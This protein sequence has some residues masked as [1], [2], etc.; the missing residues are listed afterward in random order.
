[1]S[2]LLANSLAI[3]LAYDPIDYG[4]YSA[5]YEMGFMDAAIAIVE[6]DMLADQPGVG[7]PTLRG[8]GVAFD[9]NRIITS[10]NSMRPFVLTEGS[11]EKAY[12]VV[13]KGRSFSTHNRTYHHD[14]AVYKI[15]CGRQ[16]IYVD[17]IP[18]HLWFDKINQTSPYHDL[19]VLRIDGNLTRK[20]NAYSHKNPY[21]E[22]QYYA[23]ND[24]NQSLDGLYL[25]M[26]SPV[27]K[28]YGKINFGFYYY[29]PNKKQHEVEIS[30][31]TLKVDIGRCL[32]A[33]PQ[34]WGYFLCIEYSV[35]Y[36][37]L[38]G[39]ILLLNGEVIGIGSFQYFAE[40]TN[41]ILVFTDVR[42]YRF[43]LFYACTELE[44]SGTAE[45]PLKKKIGKT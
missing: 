21:K 2:I 40:A 26:V 8:L 16:P 5:T 36:R 32:F 23:I 38:S 18:D 43:N 3:K 22:G 14:L 42:P 27:K 41:R 19:F 25:N 12:A 31:S 44:T 7:V 39:A 10:Y 17:N 6:V 11:F 13:L 33:I 9:Y 45:N 1:M 34:I 4:K 30:T 35:Y 24:F 28:F 15:V 37:F 20:T 29:V